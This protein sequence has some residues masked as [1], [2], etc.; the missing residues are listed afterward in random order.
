MDPL[1]WHI[2]MRLQD[3]RVL[4]AWPDARR[5]AARA[6]YDHGERSG[7]IAFR[8]ADTHI[9]VLVACARPLAGAFAR[10]VQCAL[11]ARLAAPVQFEPA[12]FTPVNDQIHLMRAF[13]YVLRQEA[14]HGT[15]AD[16]FHDGSSLPELVGARWMPRKDGGFIG[17]HT[18][19]RV[20][21]MLPRI[22]RRELVAE[23]GAD[24]DLTSA[25]DLRAA[26]AGALGI[27]GMD[28]RGVDRT[29]AR[30]AVVHAAALPTASLAALLAITPRAVQ[31][32]RARVPSLAAVRAVDI[33][34]RMRARFRALPVHE[35]PLAPPQDVAHG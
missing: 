5:R 32:L 12:R 11:R 4:A 16:P 33:Q 18:V 35:A 3:G 13:R 9:H 28:G 34:L 6:L 15:L 7:L 21:L 1:A 14:R 29:H 2:T 26:A 27:A 25:A 10:Q 30:V 8:V 24:G 31:Q 22:R 23:L 17:E 20:A 19:R